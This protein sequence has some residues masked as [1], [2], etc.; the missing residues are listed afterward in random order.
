MASG[1]SESSSDD[2]VKVTSDKFDAFK[3]LYSSSLCVPAVDAPVYD[4]IVKF[5]SVIKGLQ[6]GPAVKTVSIFDGF[7]CLDTLCGGPY[8]DASSIYLYFF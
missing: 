8:H 5:E 3:A 4:N 2:E 1:E 6:R 7:F